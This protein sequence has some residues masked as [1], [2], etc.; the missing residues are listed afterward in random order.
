MQD[1]ELIVALLLASTAL[2][3]LARAINVHYAI[4]LVLGGL[5]VGLVSGSS[6]PRVDP[7]IVLFVFL[8]PLIY[9]ASFGSSTQD[10]RAYARPIG[11][12]AI[13]L[14]LVTMGAV[15]VVA[16]AV[17]PIA[18]GPALVLGAILGATDPVAA[19]SVLRR[20]GAPDRISTILEGESLVNDGT[21]LTVYKLAV[22]AVISGHFSVG[23]GIV[24]F[25]AVSVGGVVIGL[26]AGWLSVEVRKRIDDPP[27]EISISLLTAYLA[28]IPAERLGASAVLAAVA[29]GLY[30]GGHTGLMLSPTSRM[31]T[32]GFWEALT[33]VL[34]S[35][36]FLLIGLQL[37]H[38]TRGLAVGKPL[39]YAAAV[40]LTLIVVRMAW[41]FIVPRLSRLARPP[42]DEPA[43]SPAEL[44]V[45]G[46]SGMR[47]GV[48]LAAALALPL[49]AGGHPF[50]DRSDVILIAYIAI[51]ATLVI[52][53]LT[54]SP[55]VRRLGLGEEEAL[56]REEARAHVALAH[57]ALRHIDE[58]AEQEDL[59]ESVAEPLRMTFEQRIHRFE[60]ELH[61][62]GTA[63]DDAA[64]AHRI[65]ELRRELI[66]VERRRLAE[67]RRRGEISAESVRRIEH[68]LDLEESRLSG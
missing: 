39:A 24:K 56:A 38:I 50:P 7:Q 64:T 29:A 37:P 32:L 16:H 17:S 20:L 51:A 12:L 40:V 19:T 67:L 61:D 26:I 60:P 54:L 43:E 53:G 14:V 52:P 63:G 35:V 42:S 30:T 55:M 33:F 22:A 18:W 15:A 3:G 36:L 8:P 27:I 49:T 31:R 48:S 44:L 1:V 28:Y 13:G 62:D 11:L 6:A 5:V 66:A 21:G 57:S 59:S 65:R 41:M 34:E 10:L 23:A 2:A 4:V 25:I 45:L 9:A 68:E 46:W 47:G 58:L